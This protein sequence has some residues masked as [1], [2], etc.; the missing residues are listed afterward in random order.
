MLKLEFNKQFLEAAQKFGDVL[1]ITYKYYRQTKVAAKGHKHIKPADLF[2]ISKAW[3]HDLVK[4]SGFKL[5]ATGEAQVETPHIF[6][7]NHLS[8]LDIA[9]LMTRAPAVFVAKN[10]IKKWPLFGSAAKVSGTMFVKRG[11][12]KSRKKTNESIGEAVLKRKQSVII[13]PSGTTCLDESKPW[14]WGA[15]E[16]AKKFD[17]PVQ[18]FRLTY[19]PLRETAFIGNDLLIP[20]MLRLFSLPDVTIT[21]EFGNS[22][23]VK[24]VKEDC[25]RVRLWTQEWFLG[26]KK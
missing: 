17:I 6:V 12:K 4:R 13:F 3:A 15:F 16:I 24:D 22:F 1:K 9:I 11:S 10:E 25:D 21:L 26:D 7:G 5:T 18:P 19:K 20:H 2:T 8:Y 23:F 14:R